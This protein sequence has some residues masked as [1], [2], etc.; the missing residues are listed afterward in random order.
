MGPCGCVLG[1]SCTDKVARAGQNGGSG[2]PGCLEDARS[3]RREQTSRGAFPTRG[4]A[5]AGGRSERRAGGQEA[6]D[7]GQ[8]VGLAHQQEDPGLHS[9][10][11][12]PPLVCTCVAARSP[13]DHLLT[14][15][16]QSLLA[17]TWNHLATLENSWAVSARAG[18]IVTV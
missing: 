11:P 9:A 1:V 3:G 5:R 7:K 2:P 4:V 8:R 16:T 10:Q 13:W 15:V 12:R 14:L 6:R 17:G 18:H